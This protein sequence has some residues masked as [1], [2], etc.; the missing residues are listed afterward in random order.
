MYTGTAT[1]DDGRLGCIEVGAEVCVARD[2]PASLSLSCRTGR[3]ALADIENQQH[4]NYKA[5]NTD[6]GIPKGL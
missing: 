4:S 5:T 3:V 2:T 6:E 1:C